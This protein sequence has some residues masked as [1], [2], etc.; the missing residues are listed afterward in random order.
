MRN[1]I[2]SLIK[3]ILHPR[4]PFAPDL[5]DMVK[6]EKDLF[7]QKRRGIALQPV[8]PI[9]DMLGGEWRDWTESEMQAMRVNRATADALYQE[10]KEL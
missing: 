7:Y 9:P 2:A 5:I 6:Y 3:A 10:V 8:R 1:P 4:P